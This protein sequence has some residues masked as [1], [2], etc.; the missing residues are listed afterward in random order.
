MRVELLSIWDLELD[1]L[2]FNFG[3]YGYLLCNF[4]EVILFRCVSFV[5]WDFNNIYFKEL[6]LRL[7]VKDIW[8]SVLKMVNIS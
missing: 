7:Y 6:F 2:S 3:F 1:V 5:K 4:V 8:N